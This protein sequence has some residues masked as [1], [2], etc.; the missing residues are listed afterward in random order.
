MPITH[1]CMIC[2]R[3]VSFVGFSPPRHNVVI[4][5]RLTGSYT[6]T[7][8]SPWAMITSYNSRH[9]KIDIDLLHCGVLLLRM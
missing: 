6:Q 4:K 2:L 9:T 5:N 1:L 7:H 8:T 3:K